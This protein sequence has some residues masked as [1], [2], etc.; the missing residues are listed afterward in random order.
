MIVTVLCLLLAP[1]FAEQTADMD[2]VKALTATLDSLYTS[3]SSSL[4]DSTVTMPSTSVSIDE[5]TRLPKRVSFF[6][7]DPHDYMTA[8]S[9]A[10]IPSS[11]NL[12]QN[13]MNMIIRPQADPVLLEVRS[14]LSSRSYRQGDY[15]L[16]GSVNF[17]YPENMTLQDLAAVWRGNETDTQPLRVT[18]SLTMF[19]S[20]L[21]QDISIT[22][23]FEIRDTSDGLLSFSSIGTYT[24]NESSYTDGFFQLDI[25]GGN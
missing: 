22:G 20:A 13:L 18:V 16:S 19:G 21:G 2:T 3:I 6:L 24:I 7:A 25:N 15:I 8:L 4:S 1:A 5:E 23:T 12:I 17:F 10:T 9:N 11:Q 14:Y